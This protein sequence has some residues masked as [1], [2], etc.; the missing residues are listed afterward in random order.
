M[1]TKK[2][3]K[4]SP[5]ASVAVPP[6]NTKEV[7][8]AAVEKAM[9]LADWKKYI[10]G[11][12]IVLKMN[13]VW[14][15]IYPCVTTSP[16]VVEAVIRLI[17]E[18]VKPKRLIIADT[19]TAAMMRTDDSFR[20]LGID[21]LAKKYG[22]ELIGLTRTKFQVVHLA[23][24]VL[25]HLKISEVLLNADCIVTLPILK[26]HCLSRMT[27]AL[28]NQWGCIHDMRHN[29]H[30]VL[31]DALADVNV[32]FKG[33]VRFAVGDVLVAMEGNG[34]KTGTPVE[35]G[36]ILAGSDLVAMDAVGATIMGVDPKNIEVITK[37]ETAKVGTKNFKIIGDKPPVIDFVKPDQK[38]QAVFLFEMALRHSGK[39]VEWFLFKTPMIYIFLLSAKIYNEIWWYLFAKQRAETMMRTR[40]GQ[41][42]R[43]YVE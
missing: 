10:Y 20:V 30:T 35:V 25:N 2:I 6:G 7:V 41:M 37:C 18:Q 26:T 13:A 38:K 11:D 9:E 16:M 19:D 14:D 32:Y 4:N 21:R 22:V 12:T 39:W 23:G 1:P 8:F 33:K 15:K 17:R 28:K 31:A 42:W 43:S 5:I 27:F 36:Y 3:A 24:R 40:W 34:P 29:L